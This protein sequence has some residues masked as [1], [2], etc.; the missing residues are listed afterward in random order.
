MAIAECNHPATW[1]QTKLADMIDFK[2]K[3]LPGPKYRMRI[4]QHLQDTYA[5]VQGSVIGD[6][7]SVT[8]LHHMMGDTATTE[9]P[10]SVDVCYFTVI[11]WDMRF[12]FCCATSL[13]VLR[14]L[15]N[16]KVF[17]RWLGLS[18]QTAVGPKPFEGPH[19]SMVS[20]YQH[21]L[22]MLREIKNFF[23]D[24]LRIIGLPI[25]GEMYDEFCPHKLTM[26]PRLPA[27]L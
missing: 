2:G 19:S 22:N 11:T 3:G 25:I 4:R 24:V 26:D 9:F 14:M 12:T 10:Y 6:S 5:L 18:F 8:S 17:T 1:V 15:W 21:H 16:R 13:T 27:S 23:M 7:N 20:S